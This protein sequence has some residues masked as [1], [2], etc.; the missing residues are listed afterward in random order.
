MKN[1]TLGVRKEA[2]CSSQNIDKE[3]IDDLVLKATRKDSDALLA[4][5]QSIAKNVLFRVMR[6]IPDRMD[7][8]DT[9]QEILLRVCE[10]IYDLDEPKAFGGWLN[11]IIINETNRMFA[12]RSG[13]EAAITDLEKYVNILQEDNTDSLPYEC[14]V[15]RE[16]RKNILEIVD[17]LPKRQLEVIMLHYYDGMSVNEVAAEMQVTAPAVSRYLSLARDKLRKYLDEGSRLPGVARS[18][19]L[20]PAGSLLSQ[21]LGEESGRLPLNDSSWVEQVMNNCAELTAKASIGAAGAG[22]AGSGIASAVSRSL[23][24]LIKPATLVSLITISV[25]AVATVAWYFS[26]PYRK[27][28]PAATQVVA[29]VSGSVEF[30]GG[31]SGHEHFNPKGI[32]VNT[33]SEYGELSV[34]SWVITTMDGAQTFMSGEG[35][36]TGDALAVLLSGGA[37]GEYLVTFTLEDAFGEEYKLGRSFFIMVD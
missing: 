28:E 5:C 9:A 23:A 27:S 1:S 8:E 24:S 4:L 31:E 37:D 16:D 29:D 33:N 32:T 11:R 26:G 25:A 36:D 21:V 2:V 3:F 6:L 18:I 20:L 13:H 12:K 34:I 17:K 14:A 15:R 30:D 35:A 19:A 10:K 7:A 22:G